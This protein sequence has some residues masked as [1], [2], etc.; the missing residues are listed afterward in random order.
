MLPTKKVIEKFTLDNIR[1]LI[2]SYP[3]VG[4]TTFANSFDSPL[5]L[6]THRG[7]KGLEVY[8]AYI[9][10]WETFLEKEKEILAGKH[11]F[12]IIVIDY[13]D[14]IHRFCLDF[15]CKK[16]RMDYPS[17][18]TH[19]K[20]WDILRTN[21][22]KPILRLISSKYG[23]IFISQSKEIEI[24][25]KYSKITKITHTIPGSQIRQM[26]NAK[27]D[28]ISYLC[29]ES[30][31]DDDGN[32]KERRI[33]IFKPSEEIEAGDRTGLLPDKIIVPKNNPLKYFRKCFENQNFKED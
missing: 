25:K 32:I 19:G 14:D 31:K 5:I 13:I 4:K 11:K 22:E 1:L 16:Y 26:I 9:D 23:I 27:V 33:M 24:T 29:I 20:G 6:D 2:H 8:P 3:K 30:Y 21:F 7:T 28:I 15:V 12:K 10:S 17:D 18:E